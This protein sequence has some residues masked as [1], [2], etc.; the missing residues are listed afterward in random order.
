MLPKSPL[1]K[2]RCLLVARSSSQDFRCDTLATAT[3]R[4]LSL[5]TRKSV[6]QA[7]G[8]ARLRIAKALDI[9]VCG[10]IPVE[11]REARR[12]QTTQDHPIGSH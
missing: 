8:E 4:G 7:R 6:L 9:A 11:Q 2:S 10:I 1:R 5:M 3:F 12:P